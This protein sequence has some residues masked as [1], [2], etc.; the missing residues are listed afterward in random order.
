MPKQSHWPKIGM[1]PANSA[2]QQSVGWRWSIGSTGSELYRTNCGQQE[3]R[4]R[5]PRVK[6]PSHLSMARFLDRAAPVIAL[7]WSVLDVRQEAFVKEC[8]DVVV[9]VQVAHSH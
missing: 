1:V 5:R 2:I 7:V 4:L 6:N 9:R 8:R 3:E